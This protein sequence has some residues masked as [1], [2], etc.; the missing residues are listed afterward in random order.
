MKTLKV[1]KIN[2]EYTDKSGNEKVVLLING[3]AYHANKSYLVKKLNLLDMTLGDFKRNTSGF[4]IV[5]E[6]DTEVKQMTAG[7]E[8]PWSNEDG[9]S[10]VYTPKSNELRIQGSF[11]F[12]VSSQLA[13]QASL[14]ESAASQMLQS[15]G[16]DLGA[17]AS[18]A[19]AAVEEEKEET[20]NIPE[21]PADTNVIS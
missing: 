6:A 4:T 10:G 11:T 20:V 1:Q 18:S 7:V 21:I 17:I 2:A 8:Y 13:F 12:E 9:T 3:F 16:L 14:K 15:L 5:C 19:K